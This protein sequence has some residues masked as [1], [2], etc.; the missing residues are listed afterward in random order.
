MLHFLDQKIKASDGCFGQN[1]YA[2]IYFNSLRLLIFHIVTHSKSQVTIWAKSNLP[3]SKP[4][5]SSSTSPKLQ[6]PLF[7]KWQLQPYNCSRQKS[8]S[9]SGLPYF[10]VFPINPLAKQSSS[11]YRIYPNLWPLL[12][13]LWLLSDCYKSLSPLPYCNEFLNALLSL[14]HQKIEDVLNIA[15]INIIF[16]VKVRPH[17][18]PAQNPSTISHLK[19][20]AKVLK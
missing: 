14:P 2:V 16:K 8:W 6:W 9:Y 15:P 20:K 17:H 5:F 11:T 3:C 7:S 4:N 19:V 1:W 13:T 10:S 18:S 12:T